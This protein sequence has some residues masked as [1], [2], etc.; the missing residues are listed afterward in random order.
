MIKFGCD[1]C[2]DSEDLKKEGKKILCKSCRGE[3]SSED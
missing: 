2:G 3:T 1:E